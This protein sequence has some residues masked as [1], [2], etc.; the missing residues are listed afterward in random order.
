MAV[1]QRLKRGLTGALFPPIGVYNLGQ[2]LAESIRSGTFP[3]TRKVDLEWTTPQDT[4]TP[5]TQ[6]PDHQ[7][8][9]DSVWQQPTTPTSPTTQHIPTQ[10]YVPA[11]QPQAQVAQPDVSSQL[12]QARAQY[13]SL[14]GRYD[15]MTPEQK[16]RFE[17]LGD[18]IRMLEAET[19]DPRQL[20]ETLDGYQ[21]GGVQIPRPPDIRESVDAMRDMMKEAPDV[22]DLRSE[23]ERLRSEYQVE[24]LEGQ[25][26]DY[27]RQIIDAQERWQGELDREGDR[28]GATLEQMRGRQ[29]ELQREMQKEIGFLELRKN[30]AVNQLNQKYETINMMMNLTVGQYELARQDYEMKFNQAFSL[31]GML[32]E[33]ERYQFESALQMAQT[34][35]D[36]DQVRQQTAMANWQVMTSTI[37]DSIQMGG[38]QSINNLT[39]EQKAQLSKVEAQA[40]LPSGFTETVTAQLRPKEE[41]LQSIV[42]QDQTKVSTIIRQPD[43]TY[44]TITTPTGLPEAYIRTYEDEVGADTTARDQGLTSAAAQRTHFRTDLL[45]NITEN[46]T[47][48]QIKENLPTLMTEW[49]RFYD[50]LD[51]D[52]LRKQLRYAGFTVGELG[53]FSR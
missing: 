7:R 18:T 10:Q 16:E 36:V 50:L 38:L 44:R 8:S 46:Y 30:V 51:P 20:Q 17:R 52:E 48:E 29:G 40:G 45:P 19:Q 12:D 1:L 5:R 43:G 49:D 9:P 4:Q 53:T 6:E 14:E 33:N 26:H 23:M 34:S 24:P 28:P 37:M 22:P 11:Q 42:S 27:D 2:D 15:Q 47:E 25:I 31:T 32:A 41:V 35:F 21:L 3:T 39:A 13:R